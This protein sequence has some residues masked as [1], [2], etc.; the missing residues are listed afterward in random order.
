MSTNRI[1]IRGSIPSHAVPL[2][3][4]TGYA[5]KEWYN[6]LRSV[7]DAV[8]YQDSDTIA[9]IYNRTY[10]LALSGD[11]TGSVQLV[12]DGT[13]TMATVVSNVDFN[14]L[15][16]RPSTLS[17]YGITDAYTKGETDTLLSGKSDTVHGHVISDTTGLQ[18][19]LDGKAAL[20]HNHAAGDVTS[21]TFADARIA[22]SNVTQHI[23]DTATTTSDFWSSD[24]INNEI[25]AVTAG[26]LATLPRESSTL[27]ISSGAITLTTGKGEAV[28]DTEGGA[29]ADTLHTINGGTLAQLLVIRT[30][31]DARD[32][33]ISTSGGNIVGAN[34]TLSTKNDSCLLLKITSGS[35]LTINF[36]NV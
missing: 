11:V 7:K 36:T 6:F 29:S 35:W 9:E 20:S 3:D 33:T 22:K 12:N 14:S 16:N 25:Q 28:V 23:D 19:A 26:A 1:P 8:F 18:S 17:G 31:N 5:S 21:G 4:A 27:T 34:F 10:T 32:V 30:I 13:A 15:T 24:K 2:V